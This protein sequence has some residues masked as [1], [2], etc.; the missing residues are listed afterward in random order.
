MSNT[1]S[2]DVP[3]EKRAGRGEGGGEYIFLGF[4]QVKS[5]IFLGFFRDPKYN[6]VVV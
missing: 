5:V 1:K 2:T 3:K 6:V 4:C